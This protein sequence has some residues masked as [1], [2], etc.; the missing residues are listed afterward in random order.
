MTT[1]RSYF[2]DF[3]PTV[4]LTDLRRFIQN[5]EDDRLLLKLLRTEFDS[6]PAQ[7]MLRHRMPAGCWK[8]GQVDGAEF[9]AELID[10]VE[11][12]LAAEVA[13]A[14]LRPALHI[15]R[16]FRFEPLP[17]IQADNLLL[18]SPSIGV[19]GKADLI[20]RLHGQP[21]LVEIKT[22]HDIPSDYAFLEHSIQASLLFAL[23]WDRPPRPM[24]DRVAILYVASTSPHRA[25]LRDVQLPRRFFHVGSRLAAHL[26]GRN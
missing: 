2:P 16:R 12:G 26:L 24:Q 3:L 22:I 15:L 13:P 6:I 7:A 18:D 4:P 21:A 14:A 19:R 10:A 5:R 23:A 20:G 9:H 25:F 8:D 1:A 11:R 17:E